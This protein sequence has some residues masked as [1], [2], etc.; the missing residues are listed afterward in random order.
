MFYLNNSLVINRNN[1][2]TI[3][4]SKIRSIISTSLEKTLMS[5][6]IRYGILKETN[7]CSR[8]R[9]RFFWIFL[10]TWAAVG[11][12]VSEESLTYSVWGGRF[13]CVTTQIRAR[14]LF[15]FH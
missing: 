15:A 1:V 6:N 3:A 8:N 13:V 7:L 4:I 14:R 11:R 5:D 10:N 2:T 12:C 9:I